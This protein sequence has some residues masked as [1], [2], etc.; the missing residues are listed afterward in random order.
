[1]TPR[2]GSSTASRTSYFGP[3]EVDHLHGDAS[4]AR[5]KLGWAP[6]IGFRYQWP[7]TATPGS[8]CT[9]VGV[10]WT[11]VSSL[12]VPEITRWVDGWNSESSMPKIG[13]ASCRERE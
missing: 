4:K 8:P 5:A 1:M 13:R 10:T 7:N 11:L 2:R 12:A 9:V 6:K 3:T